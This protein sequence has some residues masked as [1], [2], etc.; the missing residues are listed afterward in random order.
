MTRLIA[1]TGT[2]LLLGACLI[3]AWVFNPDEERRW[4]GGDS[5]P[6]RYPNS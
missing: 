6:R 5:Y 4:A 2:L 3:V 1:I